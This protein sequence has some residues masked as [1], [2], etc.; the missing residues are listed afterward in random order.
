V[1]GAADTAYS[2]MYANE[3]NATITLEKIMD[4]KYIAMFGQCEAWAD[5]RRTNMPALTPNPNAQITEIPRRL[6]TVIEERLY[7]SNAPSNTDITAP[8][9][10]DE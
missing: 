1:T 4:Q 10:W 3:N 8:V 7:N 2:N 9:W 5:W 6:P